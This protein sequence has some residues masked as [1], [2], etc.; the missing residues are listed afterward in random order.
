MGEISLGP[1]L[2][3]QAG[4]LRQHPGILG[5]WQTPFETRPDAVNDAHRI[6]NL[7]VGTTIRHDGQMQVQ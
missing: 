4:L 1:G 5:A 2:G 6:E 3:Q 7:N